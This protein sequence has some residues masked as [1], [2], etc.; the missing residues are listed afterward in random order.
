M[1]FRLRKCHKGS[2]IRA[3]Q[4]NG[5]EGVISNEYPQNLCIG[6]WS[7]PWSFAASLYSRPGI[8]LRLSTTSVYRSSV[9]HDRDV[10]W[11]TADFNRRVLFLQAVTRGIGVL[12]R[13]GV[14]LDIGEVSEYVGDTASS[15]VL[16]TP[17]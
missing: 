8:E 15:A 4:L 6:R 10:H 2:S 17:M 16:R 7:N 14:G 9:S 11:L 12:R 5:R 13:V 3:V 1:R